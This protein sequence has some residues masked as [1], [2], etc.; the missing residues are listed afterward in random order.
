MKERELGFDENSGRVVVDVLSL[1]PGGPIIHRILI[2][3]EHL[4]RRPFQPGDGVKLRELESD[5]T[6]NDAAGAVEAEGY[7]SY[8]KLH[9]HMPV[10]EV[11]CCFHSPLPRPR[12]LE[13][14]RGPGGWAQVGGALAQPAPDKQLGVANCGKE[15]SCPKHVHA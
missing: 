3:P 4:K 9:L 11:S 7:A 8:C 1:L 6:L 2:W 15:A 10:G 13:V 5:A 14:H 12:S